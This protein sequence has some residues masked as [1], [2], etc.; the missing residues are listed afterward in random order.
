MTHFW[1]SALQLFWGDVL[2]FLTT[3]KMHSFAWRI[4][5]EYSCFLFSK[6]LS[7][8]RVRERERQFDLE[9]SDVC[10]HKSVRRRSQDVSLHDSIGDERFRV[11]QS[12][13]PLCSH[14]QIARSQILKSR[15]L[16]TSPTDPWC[17]PQKHWARKSRQF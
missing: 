6:L 9:L 15:G 11:I 10:A 3:T 2:H 8:C 12:I 16:S 17:L 13:F 14:N 1:T 4:F 7:N 5:Q